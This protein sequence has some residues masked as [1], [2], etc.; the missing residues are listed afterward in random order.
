[1]NSQKGVIHVLDISKKKLAQIPDPNP[2]KDHLSHLD[3]GK[4]HLADHEIQINNLT[5][6][7]HTTYSP[8]FAPADFWLCW[9]L[10]VMLEGNSFE[11]AEALQEKV[12]DNLMSI[13]TSTSEQYLRNG[14]I[15]YCDA[16]KQVE[17]IFKITS[18]QR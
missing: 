3:N 8:D 10:K 18:S 4:A 17:S 13:P 9:Y 12:T 7:F 11:T 6:L 1:M 14:K 5:R 15:D 16:L 2:E